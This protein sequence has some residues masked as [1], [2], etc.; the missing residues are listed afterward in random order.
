M[1]ASLSHLSAWP[2]QT[3]NYVESHDDHCWID[4]ITE[5]PGHQGAFP[6]PNDRRRTHLMVAILLCSLGI[7]MLAAGQDLLRS[8]HGNPQH[9]PCRGHQRHRLSAPPRLLRVPRVL[10]PLDPV[11]ALGARPALPPRCPANRRLCALLR[12]RARVGPGGPVQRRPQPGPRRLLFAV[13]PHHETV[14]IWLGDL[15]PC[16]WRQLADHERFDAPGLD[17][18]LL[19]AAISASSCRRSPAACGRSEG[20]V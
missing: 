4:K 1:S 3:V 20:G 19:R 11:S 6:T 15:Q 13:N 17:C 7:P 12:C 5:N 16:H 18:A 14:H 10:P 2:A 8:K 9:L